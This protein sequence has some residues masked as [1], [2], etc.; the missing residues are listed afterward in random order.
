MSEETADA[1]LRTDVPH[2]ARIYDYMLGGK[3]NYEADRAAAEEIAR[4]LPA[5]PVAMRANRDFMVRMTRFL[6]RELGIRQFLDVGTGLPTSPNLHEAAQEIAPETRVVYVDNDPMVLAH[7]RTL[8]AG[9]PEGRTA[10]IDADLREP[11]AILDAARGALDLDRP[12]ALTVIAVL[13]F[14][15]DDDEALGLVRRLMEPLAPGSV[16]ALSVVPEADEAS[17]LAAGVAA[18]KAQGIPMKM[19]TRAE[20]ERFFEGLELVEPGVVPVPHWHPDHPPVPDDPIRHMYGAV[21]LKP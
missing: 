15:T 19:R 14:F 8:L 20:T 10:Y 3:D 7:A 6:V 12:V 9:T 5:L 21:A 17:P 18:Y 2:T 4:R 13:Q 16:L 1:G 11:G